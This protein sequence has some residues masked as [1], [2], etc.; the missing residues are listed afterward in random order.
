MNENLKM[1]HK[2]LVT[3]V[4]KGVAKKAVKASK[5][6]GAEGSTVIMGTGTGIHELKSFF[7]ITIE[8]E[9]EVILTLIHKEILNQVMDAVIAATK[10]DKPGNG[11]AFVIDVKKVAGIVHLL[12]QKV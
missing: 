12:R 7:G 10:L 2:L 6:A 4:K 11:I 3:I 1:K 5:E 8:P 9:K